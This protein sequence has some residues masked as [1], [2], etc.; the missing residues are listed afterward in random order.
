MVEVTASD[1]PGVNKTRLPVFS[2]FLAL[3]GSDGFDYTIPYMGLAGSIDTTP[4]M[5]SM[6]WQRPDGSTIEP[7]G[8]VEL[9]GPFPNLTST[10]QWRRVGW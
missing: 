5:H 8:T 1:P 7:G 9:P 4:A 2:G 3:N 6:A 10:Q